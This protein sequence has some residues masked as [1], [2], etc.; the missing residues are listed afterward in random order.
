MS[1]EEESPTL[2][3]IE[4]PE[5]KRKGL[6]PVF[7][8]I[9]WIALS[10]CLI[11]YNK[12]VL[13]YGG[14]EFSLIGH[15][16]TAFPIILTTWHLTFAT[17]MTQILARFTSLLDGRK[18]VKMTGRIYLRAIVPIGVFFSLSLICGNVT[19]LYLSVPFIQM[20]KSTTPVVILFFTWTFKLEPYSSKQLINV[21][22]IVIGVMISCFGEVDFVLVGVLFQIGGI[23]FEAV[24]LVM[25]QRLLSSDEFKMDPL[26][27]L[28]YFSPIC[29]LMNGAVAA[30]VELPRFRLDDVW[31]VGVWT[32]IGN[33]VVA[34]M[35]NI[36][37]VFLISKTSSLVM[38]LC[39]ILK[40]I[41][42]VISSLILWN[43][44]LTGLQVL[45][46][47][48]ALLGLIYYMLGYDRIVGFSS[49]ATG[50]INEYRAKNRLISILILLLVGFMIVLTVTGLLAVKYAPDSIQNLKSWVYYTTAGDDTT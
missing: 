12:Q 11:L 43:T 10:S 21:C 37:V 44:P 6:H 13:G 14:F 45:G 39:G 27:S 18:R 47:T 40:D 50:M 30:A 15:P 32:L 42:I 48:I 31:H 4:K 8:I 36:S 26:V 5:E 29:A 22:V 28:Y 3:M 9:A 23:V 35:L 19:Y 1:T 17:I 46:Y 24:R 25:V 38:R 7:F 2:P 41:L 33:A 49:R 34:F 16:L 20:L